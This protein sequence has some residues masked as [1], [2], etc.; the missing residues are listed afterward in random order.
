MHSC[1]PANSCSLLQVLPI[2]EGSTNVLVRRGK[3][4]EVAFL[5]N[6]VCKN[7]SLAPLLL[8]PYNSICIESRVRVTHP[9]LLAR[10]NGEGDHSFIRWGPP[11][12]SC[13]LSPSAP[14]CHSFTLQALDLLRVL[15]GDL[16]AASA[17]ITSCS[18]KLARAAA[19]GAGSGPPPSG[20]PPGAPSSSSSKRRGSRLGAGMQR[21]LLARLCTAAEGAVA[22]LKPSLQAAAAAARSAGRGQLP[23]GVQAG[24]RDLAL[25]MT[26]V[27]AAG[28]IL[29]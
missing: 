15:A 25:N 5:S 8:R 23:A 19:A 14:C 6:T 20:K 29:L 22:E 24:A 7:S 4:G 16:K 21:E 18:A 26:R 9:A 3:E 28:K 1:Y 13:N 11:F 2:W 27:F 12:S 17:F 10:R